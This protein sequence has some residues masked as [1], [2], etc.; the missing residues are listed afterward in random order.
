MLYYVNNENLCSANKRIIKKDKN[1]DN[2]KESK[3]EREKTW[4]NIEISCS[5]TCPF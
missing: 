2:L 4:S 1:K 5:I 3:P